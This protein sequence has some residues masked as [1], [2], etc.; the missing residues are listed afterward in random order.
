MTKHLLSPLMLT[1][2]MFGS[3]AGAQTL[4][5][6]KE[7]HGGD[8]RA[9]SPKVFNQNRSNY[10]QAA[11]GPAYG[12]GLASD[13]L[14]YN[15]AGSYNWNLTPR[16]TAKAI[17]DLYLGSGSV[18]SRFINLAGGAEFFIPE[19]TFMGALPYVSGVA[20]LGLVRN[21]EEQTREGLAAGAG[22]GFK[23]AADQMN[24]DVSLQY[25]VLAAQ[26]AETNPSVFG[27]RVAVNF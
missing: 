10:F 21:A 23:F 6:P 2:L 5:Q 7:A 18:S 24:L 13:S 8:L 17:G 22:A 1:A 15:I 20:G 4:D 14:M 16:F 12:V 19:A 3:L 27:A 9:P 26:I 11:I 25:T